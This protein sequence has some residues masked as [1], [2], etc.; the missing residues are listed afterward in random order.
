MNKLFVDKM[1][2]LR[3]IIAWFNRKLFQAN[4]SITDIAMQKKSWLL[5]VFL[6]ALIYIFAGVDIIYLFTVSGYVPPW[7]GYVFLILSYALNRAGKYELG[8]F[9]ATFMFPAVVFVNVLNGSSANPIATLHYLV[10]SI[11]LGGILLRKRILTIL[12][13]LDVVGIILMPELAPGIFPNY[14]ILIGPLS[15][16][17][18]GASLM[19][20]SMYHRD[21]I[22]SD[23]QKELRL[24]EERLRVALEAAHMGTWEWN[25]ETNEVK[26][27]PNVEAIF[28]LPEGG[29]TGTYDAY[30]NLI[31]P[32]DRPKVVNIIEHTMR[33]DAQDYEVVHRIKTHDNS[34]HWIEGKGKLYH[35]S[36]GKPTRMA[37]TVIDI[38]ARKNINDA[39][40]KAEE[41]YRSIFENA[42]EG[43]FQ[44]TPEGK[45]FSV[46]PAMAQMYGFKTPEEMVNNVSSIAEQVYINTADRDRLQKKLEIN[47]T[48]Q[49]FEMQD[50]RKDGSMFWSS[51]NVRAVHDKNKNIIYY[52]GTQEDITTRK[53]AEE[54]LREREAILNAVAISAELLFRA[55]EWRT[56]INTLL[57]L[58]GKSIKASHAYI[59]EHHTGPDGVLLGSMRAEWSEV[60]G[61]SDLDNPHFQNLPVLEPGLER[62]FDLLQQGRPYIG[63]RSHVTASE[64]DIL[65]ARGM[66]A[67]LDVP[68]T[69]NNSWWGV[70]GF[71]EVREERKW[72]SAEVDALRV[73]ANVL[74][75]A[76]QRQMADAELKS[77]LD[78]RK[79]LNEEL[80]AKNTELEQFTYTV[81]HDLKSPL[82]TINGFLSYLEQ[83]ATSGNLERLKS[84][85]HRI[86]EAVSKMQRLLNEL[87][88]LSRIGRIMNPPQEVPFETIAREAVNLVEGRL[89]EGRIQVRIEADMPTV[90][91]DRNRLVEVVQNLVDNAAKFMGPQENPLIEIGTRKQDD[92]YIFFVRDNGIGIEPQYHDR[93]FKLFGKLNQNSE[94]TGIGLSLVQRII[95]VHKGNIWVESKGKG[96]GATFCF[97]LP[98]ISAEEKREANNDG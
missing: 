91:G 41:M 77:E 78:Q 7:Y 82:V 62:W 36:D 1:K 16:V 44:S 32:E 90:Y 81:S 19:L 23:R 8:A 35:N 17:V 79:S 74:G 46:N 55:P 33:G 76:I 38:T 67:V 27:S 6:I 71:D 65:K 87:L 3:R 52:E 29:F 39:L 85:I 56:E 59:F 92:T 57:E 26:W 70:I 22:E 40:R 21:L 66:K 20:M 84:D 72:T 63:D 43:I 73:A 14:Y 60:E 61:D 68:I 86:Q 25:I 98:Q 64:M 54:N 80:A 4:P 12:V 10:L 2:K 37:G 94:G 31:L 45:F 28:G 15:S 30:L 58:L 89:N 47:G 97:T 95:N 13:V 93:I 24:S 51:M 11:I 42:V 88:E 69:V 50:R 48:V 34:I 9:L 53:L 18:I 96:T 83:D 5:S 49:G 75:A